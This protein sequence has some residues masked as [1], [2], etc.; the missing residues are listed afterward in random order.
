MKKKIFISAGDTSGDIHAAKLIKHLK[1]LDNEIDFIG[2]GGIEMEKTGFFK[3]II[4]LKEISVVGFWEVAK[5]IQLFRKLMKDSLSLIEQEN[6]SLFL[7]VD[8]PGFN[9]ELAK[10]LKKKG[11]TK[12]IY[13][14]APQLWAWGKNRAEKLVNCI[15]LL[16]VVFPFEKEFFNNFKI[17]TE[18]VG[19]PLL[20]D[21]IF[22]DDFKNYEDR[23]YSC[24]YMPG[25]RK[26]EIIKHLPL[27]NQTAEILNKFD[28][29]LENKLII[30]NNIDK[31]LIYSRI[32]DSVHWKFETNSKE[33]MRDSLVGVIKTG[34]SNLEAALLGI[35]YNMFYLTSFITYTLGKKLVNIDYLA[36]P[37]IIMKRNVIEE[38]IQQDATAEKISN[39]VIKLIKDKSAYKTMQNDFRNLKEYI[40]NAGASAKAAKIILENI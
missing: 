37:N 10:N 26:Q 25:S 9:I 11:N 40:G 6:I 16:L 15:D 20:D 32:N 27:L 22:S 3:S 13:Y 2:I 24:I 36:L 4:P 39:N 30:S 35:P 31:E 5:K 17:N 33:Q 7:P 29:S 19:H 28:P 38:F 34:T 21:E 14:I 23:N 12:V 8:Y 18:F 1:A